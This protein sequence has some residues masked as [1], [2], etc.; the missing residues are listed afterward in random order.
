MK[1]DMFARS[2]WLAL[3]KR[4]RVRQLRSAAVVLA[5]LF[6]VWPCQTHADPI[7]AL[8]ATTAVN[9]WLS[10]DSD[11]MNSGISHSTSD[12]MA[13][14]GADGITNAFYVVT[15]APAGYVIVAADDLV[16]GVLAFSSK[17][18]FNPS[19]NSTFYRM[20]QLDLPQRLAYARDL[21]AKQGQSKT[22]PLA[23]TALTGAQSGSGSGV[24]PMD[25]IPHPDPVDGI[26]RVRVAPLITSKW[27]QGSP[28]NY[29]TPSNASP[30]HITIFMAEMIR[31]HQ[32]QPAAGVGRN[33]YLA[34]VN[35]S[36]QFLW[37][38]GGDGNGGPYVWSNMVDD[39]TASGTTLTQQLAVAT[40]C[41]D[42]G[43]AV[44]HN[45][46]DLRHGTGEDF[47]N[48]AGWLESVYAFSNGGFFGRY[49]GTDP[50]WNSDEWLD[51]PDF[52][53]PPANAA[54]GMINANLDA[55]LPVLITLQPQNPLLADWTAACDGYGYS[56][57]T[58]SGPVGG[59]WM[60]HH[61]VMADG[62]SG[63][64]VWYTLPVVKNGAG[65]T[66]IATVTYNII[67][68]NKGEIVSGR[69]VDMNNF[70]M[71]GITILISNDTYTATTITTNTGIYSFIVP[72]NTNYT[73]SV[74]PPVGTPVTW[75]TPPTQTITVGK[76][77]N[78]GACG[79]VW[80]VNFKV[81]SHVIAGR[82]IK[83]GAPLVRAQVTFSNIV[84]ISTTPLVTTT[85]YM[86]T[87]QTD[88]DGYFI[89]PVPNNW[90]GIL[91]PLIPGYGGSF[92]PAFS[93]LVNVTDDSHTN[94]YF[95]W[96]APTT[97]AVSGSVFRADSDTLDSVPN[98]LLSFYG[99]DN[100]AGVNFTNYTDANGD[101]TQ[102]VPTNWVGYAVATDPDGGSFTPA[103]RLYSGDAFASGISSNTGFQWYYWSAPTTNSISGTVIRRDNGA[104]VT[105]AQLQISYGDTVTTGPDGTYTFYNVPYEWAG[106][107]TISS[108]FGGVFS[109]NGRAYAS[110][111]V[112]L[113][114]QNFLWTPPV[115]AIT[116]V[117]TSGSAPVPGVTLRAIALDPDTYPD[118]FLAVT[119]VDGAYVL[120]V[121]LGWSGTV[122]PQHPDGGTFFPVTNSYASVITNIGPVNYEWTPPA[123]NTIRGRIT[124]RDTGNA[125]VGVQLTTSDGIVYAV[126]DT[127]GNYSIPVNYTWSGT[128]TPS[129]LFGGTFLPV[130]QS[131]TG[132]RVPTN[133][134]DYLWVPPPPTVIGT[135]TSTNYPFGPVAG[136]MIN[137]AGTNA[138]GSV[139]IT[140]AVTAADG[141]YRV[142]LPLGVAI[143]LSWGGTGTPVS[144]VSGDSFTPAY[145]P[146][147]DTPTNYYF[148]QD[149][150][151]NP[152]GTWTI[153]GSI[154][155]IG[156][157]AAVTNASI[158]FVSAGGAVTNTFHTDALG[159]YLAYVRTNWSGTA[160]PTNPA[161]GSFAPRTNAYLIVST[162]IGA[163]NYI[164]TPPPTVAGIVTNTLGPVSGV[165]IRLFG[166]N[167]DSTVVN[168]QT[169]TAAD[170]SYQITLP[171]GWS[172]TGTP[173]SVTNG[174]S[175][176]PA[177]MPFF[178]TST[179]YIFIQ[180]YCWTPPPTV[181]GI[182]TS[183]NAP[184]APVPGV[185]I[186]LFGT[187]TDAMIVNTQA[188]TAADGTYRIT[189]PAGWSGSGTPVS[190]SV[191]DAFT[192]A[193]MPFINT[194]TNWLFIQN[195][196]WRPPAPWAISGSVFRADTEANVATATI[197]FTGANGTM[198]NYTA[199]TDANG[200]YVVLVTNGW[201][202]IATPQHPDGGTF[203]P[204]SNV[205]VNVAHNIGPQ[206]YYW[207]PPTTNT[208]RGRVIMRDTGSPAVGVQLTTSDG[209][210]YTTGP[211]GTYTIPV[212]YEWSGSVTLSSVFG[213][214][215]TPASRAYPI[216]RVPLSNEDYLWTPPPPTIFGVVTNTTYPFGP[217]SNVTVWFSGSVTNM[218]VLNTQTVT[219]ADGSYRM[220]VPVG[221]S[222]TATPSNPPGLSGTFDPTNMPFIDTVTNSFF[223][224]NYTWVPV[225]TRAISGLVVRANSTLDPVTNAV[226]TFVFTNG[227][228]TNF[229]AYTDLNG[230]YVAYV[231]TNWT[232]TAT[233]SDPVGGSFS[234]VTNFYPVLA[235]NIG[236]QAYF[237][238][239]PATITISGTVRLRNSGKPAGGVLLTGSGGYTTN[240]SA[241]GTYTLT[242]PYEWSGTLSVSSP[243][244]GVFSPGSLPY[245]RV[246]VPFTGQDFWWTMPPPIVAG[247]VTSTNYPFGPVSNVVIQFSGTNA[248]G[249]ASATQVVTAVDGSYLLTLPAGWS[250]IGTPVRVTNGDSFTPSFMPFIDTST[251]CYF[252][253][254][255]TWHPLG[256]WAVSG[257]VIRV[258]SFAPMT[259]VTISFVD[260]N[261]VTTRTVSTDPSGNF[262]AFIPTNWSGTATPVRL[263]PFD[264]YSP[265]NYTYS[266]L[267][268]N[269][270]AQVFYWAPPSNVRISG[271][272]TLHGSGKPAAGVLL[273]TSD[274]ATTNALAD[275]SYTFAIP[276][277]WSGS[278]TV[279]SPLGGVFAPV[280]YAY[281]NVQVPIT[282]GQDYAWTPPL[283]VVSGVVTSTN[284]PFGP[285]SNVTINFIGTNTD[286]TAAITSA[287]TVADGS[288]RLVLPP[289]WSGTGTPVSVTS[290]DSFTPFFMPF[291]DTT[292]NF[293]F[294]QNYT[295]NPP[296]TFA[297][298]GSVVRV[299][300]MLGVTNAW[301][302]FLSTNGVV[303]TNSMAYTDSQGYYV[304]YV[305]TN[306]SGTAVP[307]H[308]DSG[309]FSPATNFYPAMTA[310]RGFQNY[311]WTPPTNNTISGTILRRDSGGPAVGIQ[312]TTSDGRTFTT[313]VNGN[314][315]IP[316]PYEWTGT[317]TPSSSFGG[318]FDI[319]GRP[320]TVVLRPI[321]G[322]NYLW[323]PPATAIVGIVTNSAAPFG[324]VSNVLITF[325]GTINTQVL[326]VADGSYRIN[327]P[328]G[329]IGTATPSHPWGGTFN[330]AHMPQ[331]NMATN[332]IFTQ[333]YGWVPPP[334]LII[335]GSIWR[336]DTLAN[337]TNAVINFTGSGAF[338]SYTV[339]PAS[340]DP[341]GNYQAYVPVNW[342]GTATPK[343]PDLGTF[344]PVM[345]FY[346]PITANLGFQTYL[347][348]PPLTNTISGTVIRRDSGMPV[349]GVLLSASG[350]LTATTDAS[351]Y[352]SIVGVPYQ[353]SG[354]V[355]PSHPLGGVFI[356]GSVGYANVRASYGTQNYQWMPPPPVITGVV[357]RGDFGGPA[358]G[359]TI[360]LSGGAGTT[361][362][363]GDGTYRVSVAAGWV[364]TA[365][366]SYPA[367]VGGSFTPVVTP[368]INTATNFIFVENFA[369]NPPSMTISG[370][371]TQIGGAI[372][373]NVT[374]T[375]SDVTNAP[376]HSPTLNHSPTLARTNSNGWYFVNVPFGWSGLAVPTSPFGGSFLPGSNTYVN[377]T[378]NRTDPYNW[379]PPAPSIIGRVL[380]FDTGAPVPGVSLIF[381]NDASLVSSQGATNPLTVAMTDS[382]GNYRVSVG[383]WV[384][385]WSGSITPVMTQYTG[386]VF[387][388]TQQVF[389]GV[390]ADVSDT[391]RTQF[392]L[393]PPP[394]YLISVASPT[395]R[396]VVTGASNG[397]Y[398]VGASLS[399]TAMPN[400]VSR[401]LK[402]QDGVSNAARTVVLL[403]G[404]N[405][406][407]AIFI[408]LGPTI[409]FRGLDPSG[410]LDFGNVLVGMTTS[411]TIVV[412]NT[413][414]SICNVMGTATPASPPG[415]Y[416][417]LPTTYTLNPGASKSVKI[418]FKPPSSLSFT[419]V[420]TLATLPEP[421]AGAP[422]FAVQGEGLELV[423][424]L[425]VT[426][427]YDFGTVLVG[428]RVSRTIQFYNHFSR[429]LSLSAK[430]SNGAGFTVSGFPVTIPA[431][432]IKSATITFAPTV[433]KDYG[434]A[435]MVVSA[436]G[437]STTGYLVPKV[438]VVANVGGTWTATLNKQN[439]TLYLKQTNSIVDG[440]MICKQNAAIND[441][442]VA[443]ITIG[444]LT[445]TLYYATN[446]VGS[447][448]LTA[449]ASSLAGTFTRTGVGLGG[450][451][452][453]WT[454][455]STTVPATIHF[456]ARPSLV[457][458]P[459]A[460][461]AMAA[462][463]GVVV[464]PSVAALHL[465]LLDLAPAALLPEDSELVV[466]TF[467]NGR[468][469]ASSPALDFYNL[470]W[471]LQTRI[472]VEG[473]DGNTNGLPD[474]IEAALG[475][476][477][478]EG[479]ELLVV[480]KHDGHAVPDAPY[481]G[482]AVEGAV[483]PVGSLPATWTLTPAKP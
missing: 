333:N 390:V 355:V 357:V 363:A 441:Q 57:G 304:A 369:W 414:T 332:F 189:L 153:S 31:L 21:Q 279:S 88:L 353:W 143:P 404:T 479:M 36:P 102:Q 260:T 310:N 98:V 453:T 46:Y 80:G 422:A 15:L 195:Y 433:I 370:L 78:Y 382:N 286:G 415:A 75:P 327:L 27:G 24:Q 426:S 336:A 18:S 116:G 250:G 356:P 398:T 201:S 184:F 38:R 50:L 229:T 202:G 20:L 347:W 301:I 270:G 321:S 69:V 137:F 67:P 435:I 331:V 481:S 192:P 87:L 312:L 405:T 446:N 213:G 251:N 190:V 448:M 147:I 309:T 328:D 324:P 412:K 199:H 337:V 296:V 174:D 221:W 94:V 113:S 215:F 277:A 317:I 292:L 392:I 261:G 402:W 5:V 252:V 4:L 423:D 439:Y 134:Q 254:N 210:V 197:T 163:Q 297:I 115:P 123:T 451:A 59:Y 66:N 73:V 53:A 26:C 124:N 32:Q 255:Y 305:P 156:T 89:T 482:T 219:V 348:T 152:L 79:N 316:T 314:Y 183:A 468:P 303:T 287:V 307:H 64:N 225:E 161:G 47:A 450:Q 306:W 285:V 112:P 74:V 1:N 142:T 157:G 91:T 377:V 71:P 238:T 237:W 322:Q 56:T 442:Y 456:A 408:D 103:Q 334:M 417:A 330:P 145:M 271:R 463:A 387:S 323:T 191:G 55:G 140:S 180:N 146:F 125:A 93:N 300:S 106:Q 104:V 133:G 288:Y 315:S 175:F 411:R 352:Y 121:P 313:D 427:N 2:G 228:T 342:T 128:V 367:V 144:V 340:T 344:S 386:A 407:T 77:S 242:V 97:W 409:V 171:A 173:V 467:K 243:F 429:P 374:V 222:G 428:Q 410:G 34:Q 335:S 246:Q 375:F 272:V 460:A 452:S 193:A 284:Y 384:G 233:P 107:I 165:T 214:V 76:S 212:P 83:E 383:N 385:G 178:D 478:C 159:N 472:E 9:T 294:V 476:P 400:S 346:P 320:Y 49:D 207:T 119:A 63:D 235:T 436:T 164:W 483:V 148:R 196:S 11:P 419:G 416:V 181:A 457:I 114:G 329:W 474:L 217:V 16:G 265:T 111:N 471:L 68:R 473:A 397:W 70:S 204:L 403:P 466:V 295:W 54:F 249:S 182:V 283:P 269:V 461:V 278:I 247:V 120:R 395:L 13:Y 72:G 10:S 424:V 84:T 7:T 39:A 232:G 8:Q 366:P 256:T 122:I 129:D 350:G 216:V 168:T 343:H 149:Y 185:T 23:Q 151:W 362:T 345:N 82:I 245:N 132:V 187:N 326:T 302:T 380:R 90:T 447:L 224:Q 371:V 391:N 154:L 118:P 432:G 459:A 464:A 234:P 211:D 253:Q 444:S 19:P 358:S 293:S 110:V 28:Y 205:Y 172:G 458:K 220:I 42:V 135:V 434:G 267:A 298:S 469:V 372:V 465:T 3:L 101:Y 359:V 430:W 360:T 209:L 188:V 6:A 431:G 280:S 43:V 258:V 170:G 420:V 378:A 273:T 25:V 30:G 62:N 268:R 373:T 45:N 44:L 445:G 200:N 368:V 60:F 361:L 226:I 179:N 338:S 381:S 318:V 462:P 29:F 449:S 281:A 289:G 393:H 167:A 257:S 48:M 365:T 299:G 155:R 130:S 231:P 81:S 33:Y 248:D 51:Y 227:V 61:L 291:I 109:P 421:A 108:P 259:N 126:T 399:I 40:L 127:N 239:P 230:N 341:N 218:G 364:G 85:N 177:S 263:L 290:G 166:T 186:R 396:G 95:T 194:A 475:V 376:A 406:Y 262:V 17:G 311:L 325:T 266:Q 169:V 470:S 440:V 96:N 203:A 438:T 477:L 244:G 351:G 354:T 150:T 388:P 35:E 319:P 139:A 160:T 241:D 236:F 100:F 401:F 240:T 339:V 41:S 138:D 117:V 176:T 208:I 223:I 105:N 437:V 52:I 14:P 136:V 275:G 274:G 443:G 206:S 12:V 131:Y 282:N 379:I 425:S 37:T 65:Y 264:S 158:A 413:G 141:T 349:A 86:L 308:P 198:P 454:R 455:S 389:A 394:A 99:I 276:F 418:T 92:T 162:N 480:R 22:S 58:G